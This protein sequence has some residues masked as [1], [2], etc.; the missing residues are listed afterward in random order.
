MQVHEELAHFLNYYLSIGSLVLSVIV[1]AWAV[2]F[3][4]MRLRFGPYKELR[5]IYK[6]IAFFAL[7]LGCI[8]SFS[9]TALSLF[10]SEYLGYLPCALCWFQ[11][12]A[13]YPLCFLFAI[14]WYRKDFT[15]YRYV[16][17]LSGIGMVISLY[18]EYLQLGYAE[19]IPCSANAV[20]V[21]CAK[22]SFLLFGFVTFPYIAGVFFALLFLT[23]LTL[24]M[25]VKRGE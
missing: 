11:R 25:K 5:F 9:G 18:H 2:D 12:V 23:A 21:D 6:K 14:A 24:R 7:P 17:A 22:P 3:I 16:L 1:I 8:I 19:L 13:L 4:V 20:F 10:Y 15:V